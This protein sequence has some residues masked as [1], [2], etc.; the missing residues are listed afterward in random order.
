VTDKSEQE[1]AQELIT[2]LN[3]QK[4]KAMNVSKTYQNDK[5][6]YDGPNETE[7]VYDAVLQYIETVDSYL[8][9]IT[10]DIAV[11]DE[12]LH[13]Y[14]TTTMALGIKLEALSTLIVEEGLLSSE[15]L[16]KSLKDLSEKIALQT[17]S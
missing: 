9:L 3:E 1:W 5:T 4:N 8:E 12:T 10:S 11:L 15:Q 14:A 2:K 16:N 6:F 13:N 7:V 17:K